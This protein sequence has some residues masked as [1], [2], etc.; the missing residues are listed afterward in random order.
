MTDSPQSDRIRI[1]QE[2]TESSDVQARIE[3]MEQAQKVAL[4]R[5]VGDAP[6]K[7]GSGFGL[8]VLTLTLGGLVGGILA[9]LGQ[10]VLFKLPGLSTLSEEN[11]FFSNMAFTFIL[12]MSIGAAVSLADV[13]T[14][15]NWAKLGKVAA[16][17]LPAAAG[18]A[19]LI[20]LLAHFFYSS[21]QEWL[22][23]SAFEKVLSGE[24][25]ENTAEDYVMLRLHPIRGFAWL[26]VGISAGIAAGAAARSW[27]RLGLAAAGGALGGFLGGFVFDFIAQSDGSEWVAQLVGIAL[28]GTLIG[29]STGLLEQ[30]GKSRWIEI[31]AGG[32]AGKQFIL[33]KNE[34]A[35]GS[36][37]SADVTLIKDSRI[38][39]IAAVIRAQG[40][41]CA[42]QE[43]A[44]VAGLEVNGTPVSRS[45]LRDMDLI[46]IG[47]TQIR[48][49]E[50]ASSNKV[51][52]ALRA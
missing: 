29:L 8:A 13:A 47:G 33:Y 16:I 34:V 50:K 17:A 7:G 11:V 2:D 15:R 23:Q 18:S 32:L 4:V 10:L 3:A 20:G 30:A 37:P 38:A 9:F 31:V 27:K 51:P 21:A 45:D 26:L 39:P 42:I 24:L 44:G 1:S 48:F 19:L 25:N 40:A 52:G 41:S 43:A 6:A 49:R 22:F 46:T 28:L 14:N 35:L 5:T 36:S 12:A